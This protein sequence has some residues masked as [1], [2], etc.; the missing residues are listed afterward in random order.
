MPL[1]SV[2]GCR[3]ICYLAPRVRVTGG[4]FACCKIICSLHGLRCCGQYFGFT[5]GRTV[6]EVKPFA[7]SGRPGDVVT[8]RAL[9]FCHPHTCG[10]PAS[11]AGSIFRMI[12]SVLLVIGTIRTRSGYA[13]CLQPVAAYSFPGSYP[14]QS[15][16]RTHQT[17]PLHVST[18][19]PRFPGI[20][21]SA[22]IWL[23]FCGSI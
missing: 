23:L 20:T 15:M 11:T 14:R 21:C 19:R 12:L 1:P 8:V 3:R 6:T 7:V 18:S 9:I 5:V 16:P 2:K 17:D 22:I 4:C 13:H 10:L